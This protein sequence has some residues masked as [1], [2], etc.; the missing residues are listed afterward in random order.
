MELRRVTPEP[1][2]PLQTYLDAKLVIPNSFRRSQLPKLL[3]RQFVL[4][5]IALSSVAVLA[6]CTGGKTNT[7]TSAPS[8]DATMLPEGEIATP[9]ALPAIA[10]PGE[11]PKGL[12]PVWEA[13]TLLV[14]EYVEREKIDPKKMAEG[15]I[16]GMV[17][18]LGDPHTA[19][20]SPQALLMQS[21]ELQGEFQG[22]GAEIQNSPDGKRIVIVA[23]IKGSPAEAAGIKPGDLILTVDGEDTEGWSVIEAVSK[24]RGPKG[25]PV[26]LL[27]RRLNSGE[28]V[29][30]RIVRGVI[31]QPSVKSRMLEDAPYGVIVI[32]Q[33]TAKSGPE[34]RKAIA[35]LKAKGA[36]GLIIDLRGNP[37]GLL[38]TTVEI[39][40]EFLSAGLVTYEVDGRGNRRDW[41][42][43]TGGTAKDIPL[44]VLID[45]GSASGSEIL[46]GALQGKC[47]Q[48]RAVV[49]GQKSFGKGSVNTMRGLSNDGGL[50]MTVARWYSP[51]GCLIEGRGIEP[52]VVVSLPRADRNNPNFEDTQMSAAIKQLNFQTGSA[53][54]GR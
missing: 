12:E 8:S 43:K 24:I 6:A 31:D 20:V 21:S 53:A 2:R 54:A 42:V 39:S 18:T 45:G 51:G 11:V 28:E 26:D 37:G 16:R 35:Q 3:M 33:F 44:V 22:I 50:Y 49:I 4:L 38:S 1:G 48:A 5:I 23:P 46:A 32:D 7:P 30:V 29:T 41:K 27:I 14:Q 25:I 13:Y 17:A 15:A 52:D 47:G 34:V 36:K 19:Y 9:T 10:A 40:S